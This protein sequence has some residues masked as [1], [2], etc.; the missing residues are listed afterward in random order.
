MVAC[1][2]CVLEME[3]QSE[4]QNVLIVK[5]EGEKKMYYLVKNETYDHLGEMC[6]GSVKVQATGLSVR[7]A[8]P[9]LVWNEQQMGSTTHPDSTEA[10]FKSAQII[11]FIPEDFA[12]I[13]LSVA[14][15]VLQNDNSIVALGLP[16]WIGIELRDPQPSPAIQCHRNGLGDIGLAGKH[17]DFESVFDCHC[18]DRFG[19]R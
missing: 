19:R 8:V 10:D 6:K 7:H 2:K 15:G 9:I 3:G 13:E 12:A 4:C 11:S 16:L 17:A 5:E 1:A 14:V 18:F